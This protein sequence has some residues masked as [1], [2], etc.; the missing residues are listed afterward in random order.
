MLVDD[1]DDGDGD[2]DDG[3]DDGVDLQ[4]EG[5]AWL[6]ASLKEGRGGLFQGNRALVAILNLV[7]RVL[8]SL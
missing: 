3:D 5:M 8:V 1:G 6:V 7:H 4:V 2:D